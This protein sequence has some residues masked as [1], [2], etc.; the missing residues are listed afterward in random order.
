[1]RLDEIEE[2]VDGVGVVEEV[3][4]SPLDGV[5]I[6]AETLRDDLIMNFSDFRFK[7]ADIT[8]GAVEQKAYWSWTFAIESE[9]QC[10]ECTIILFLDA[11]DSMSRYSVEVVSLGGRAWATA[12][13][14]TTENA[15]LTAFD[16]LKKLFALIA[17]ETPCQ[18]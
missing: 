18:E 8:S 11:D 7:E 13:N 5:L 4:V 3:E 2:V 6:E 14:C 12:N 15:A 10:L 1:M 17:Q 16:E 9:D